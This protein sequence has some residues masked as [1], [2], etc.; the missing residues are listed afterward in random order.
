M[1]NGNIKAYKYRIYPNKAQKE[2]LA[3]KIKRNG[4]K[5]WIYLII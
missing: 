3:K 5:Q 4:Q 1:Y 2:L